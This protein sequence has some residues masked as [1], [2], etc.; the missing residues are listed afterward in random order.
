MTT[1]TSMGMAVVAGVCA[2]ALAAV[3]GARE[4]DAPKGGCCCDNCTCT[5]CPCA[6]GCDC[7]CGCCAGGSCCG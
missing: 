2:L 5:D 4:S 3:A 6:G 1:R 7:G